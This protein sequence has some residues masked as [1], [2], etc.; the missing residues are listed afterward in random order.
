[1]PPF[2]ETSKQ[3]IGDECP[4]KKR[5]YSFVSTSIAINV[6]PDVKSMIFSPA[7]RDHF[8]FRHLSGEYPITCLSSIIGSRFSFD[9]RFN[10]API[11]YPV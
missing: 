3:Q 9:E 1:M 8:K 11:Y 4:K 7:T 10:S 6:P 5:F 2:E